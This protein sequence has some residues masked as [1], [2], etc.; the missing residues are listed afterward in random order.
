MGLCKCISSLISCLVLAIAAYML[1]YFLGKPESVDEVIEN[2]SQ[3]GGEILNNLGDVLESFD[4]GDFDWS[5]MFGDL[6]GEGGGDY[7]G[8]SDETL[9]WDL[10]SATEHGLTLTLKNNLD[11][12]WQEEYRTAVQNWMDSDPGILQLETIR[13][14]G[15][16]KDK[17]KAQDGLMVVC[18][19]NESDN[20]ML[21]FNNLV[22][23]NK[24]IIFSSVAVMNEYYL[25]NADWDE[26][27]YTMCHELGHGFGLDHTDENPYNKDLGDCM[28]YTDNPSANILPG[29]VNFARLRSMY[30]EVSRR[31]GS[32]L[33]RLT[34]SSFGAVKKNGHVSANLEQ[35]YDAAME[36]LKRHISEEYHAMK[37]GEEENIDESARKRHL[38]GWRRLHQ[39]K[40][41]GHFTRELVEGYT[42]QTSVLYPRE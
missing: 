17:C 21:G 40:W 29:D 16:L 20:G 5:K 41:S 26:R 11:E 33:R 36:D 6:D 22:Y 25:A 8:G 12:N 30:G 1:W 18:N 35:A 7:T 14:D 3:I 15:S 34:S 13:V 37:K 9:F 39:N 32:S 28:D 38:S 10:G 4:I 24:G 19:E 31:L 42:I 27:L 23:D 2:G